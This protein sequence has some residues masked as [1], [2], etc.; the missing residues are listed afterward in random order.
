[1]LERIPA[2]RGGDPADLGGAAVFLASSASDLSTVTSSPST[3]AGWRGERLR[4]RSGSACRS[5]HLLPALAQQEEKPFDR[6]RANGESA[7]TVP[8][9]VRAELVEALPFFRRVA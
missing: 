7:M 9:P 4:H 2:A 8:H 3:A 1:M 6:L 5:A